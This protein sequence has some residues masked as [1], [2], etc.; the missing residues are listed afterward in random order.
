MDPETAAVV[1][2]VARS[3]VSIDQLHYLQQR[4]LAIYLSTCSPGRFSSL[5]SRPTVDLAGS[6]HY[7]ITTLKEAPVAHLAVAVVAGVAIV[8]TWPFVVFACAI[9]LC[10]EESEAEPAG[11]F[12]Q[13]DQLEDLEH[14][15]RFAQSLDWKN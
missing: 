3:L 11:K 8:A 1:V 6:E 5:R 2:Y 10:V 15:V 7:W 13:V 4:C 14:F 9:A 12:D